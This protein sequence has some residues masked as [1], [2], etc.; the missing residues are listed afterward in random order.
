MPVS[1]VA[2]PSHP[3]VVASGR[4]PIAMVPRPQG[5]SNLPRSIAV[6][7]DRTVGKPGVERGPIELPLTGVPREAL[8]R[9]GEMLS[10]RALTD[11]ELATLITGGFGR[12]PL[13]D[14]M[15]PRLV[16]EAL[17]VA[18]P[19]ANAEERKIWEA[20]V[21][22]AV[23][24]PVQSWHERH[25]NP[26][27]ALVRP[28][29]SRM[30]NELYKR[31]HESSLEPASWSGVFPARQ[32]VSARIKELERVSRDATLDTSVPVRNGQGNPWSAAAVGAL[33]LLGGIP[34]AQA[35][36]VP[37]EADGA[38]AQMPLLRQQLANVASPVVRCLAPIGPFITR[39]PRATLA[40]LAGTLAA[41]LTTALYNQ[42]GHARTLV[43]HTQSEKFAPLAGIVARD[44]LANVTNQ[45]RQGDASL[46]AEDRTL[47]A[48]QALG[49]AADGARLLWQI[50]QHGRSDR[51]DLMS[52]G[53]DIEFGRW[54]IKQVFGD[55]VPTGGV[56]MTWS[57]W[58][59]P[60]GLRVILVPGKGDTVGVQLR[61]GDGS[62]IERQGQRGAVH[63]AEHLTF[64]RNLPDNVPFDDLYI[65]A[66]VTHNAYTTHDNTVYFTEG[67]Q[68]ALELILLEKSY[69]LAHATDPL[70]PAQLETERNVVFNELR[71]RD[72]S[73]QRASEV[74]ARAMYP[75]G[76]PYHA[77]P[78]GRMDDL[79]SLQPADVENLMRA[80]Q[81]PNLA[82]LVIS[83]N[84]DEEDVR[85]MV[86]HY[87]ADIEPG[88]T[89]PAAKP[90][91]QP[92]TDDTNDEMFDKVST[93]RLYRAWNVPQ[94]GHSDLPGLTLAARIISQ[95]LKAAL[96]N[97]MVFAGAFVDPRELGSQL[98][99]VLSLRGDADQQQ[100]EET[101]N[102]VMATF[103]EQ[104]PSGEEVESARRL[105]I[106]AE[107]HAQSSSDAI[108]TAVVH[109][110]DRGGDPDCA[111]ADIQAWHEAT[112]ASVKKV[113]GDWLARGSH[114]LLVTPGE[115][116]RLSPGN[117]GERRNIS[118][119]VGSPDPTLSATPTHVD[120]TVLPGMASPGPAFFPAVL[121]RELTNDLPVILAPMR[122]GADARV[123]FVFHGG[124]MGDL[125]PDT[126]VG[127]AKA[128]LRVLTQ[129]AGALEG[130]ALKQKLD[131][132]ELAVTARST[133]GYSR[134]TLEGPPSNLAQGAQIVKDMLTDTRFPA[135][136]LDQSHARARADMNLVATHPS[137]RGNVLM[138]TLVLG[139][140]H[141]YGRDPVGEGTDASLVAMSPAQ[142]ERWTA[143]YLDPSNATIV[144]VGP[145]DPDTLMGDLAASFGSV[146]GVGER[147]RLPVPVPMQ[148]AHP[149][150]HVF[151]TD[152]AQQSQVM[153]GYPSPR[154]GTADDALPTCIDKIIQRRV[155]T[156]LRE[157]MGV[158]Y[159]V[160]SMTTDTRGVR[161]CG[162]RSA[163]DAAYGLD[164]LATARAVV[165]DLLEGSK[166]VMQPELDLEI[167]SI[168]RD[169]AARY[170][171]RAEVE[172]AL[173]TAI[174]L[175]S[176]VPGDALAQRLQSL[177]C[178]DVNRAA[179]RMSAS[180]L[181]WLVSIPD[182][183]GD[184]PMDSSEPDDGNDAD[185]EL[186]LRLTGMGL[187]QF[188]EV[189]PDSGARTV[190]RL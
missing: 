40:T 18:L 26:P 20:V 101:L 37:G 23:R 184:T 128:A 65:A 125:D 123:V 177:T 190:H 56:D 91:I 15:A 52:P 45:V 39:H 16:T 187:S 103:L 121:R 64:R 72:D 164:A 161:M 32:G 14:A 54:L 60:N 19:E 83:G 115:R 44:V 122:E 97:E 99:I 46:P 113:V 162:F 120:R 87:F 136:L 35:E 143:R 182:A 95:R 71:Q 147:H 6:T 88:N 51:L 98:K 25:A 63:L 118:W 42:L 105:L 169:L 61:F 166:P 189:D 167:R 29:T 170:H 7:R 92:R 186:R 107:A 155:K 86:T 114:T 106:S 77:S 100:V 66:G 79:R 2:S 171:D 8:Q 152:Q 111:N 43:P 178:D 145:F 176:D 116:P 135:H 132:L 76:H 108:A 119:D 94:D 165:S 31:L 73:A 149:G 1:S 127:V 38:D 139:E 4:L 93:P 172:S 129:R 130:R 124:R 183:R 89:F 117:A 168:R 50:D 154:D 67:P 59:L 153:L 68:D 141:P 49:P 148:S 102:H 80:R 47:Q 157:Q 36:I 82:T 74:M 3:P 185:T 110:L 146:S 24:M 17:L 96:E 78:G 142:L 180:H 174:D 12:T 5:V 34:A 30:L 53:L 158:T 21:E 75:Y 81:R 160:R 173:V 112:P 55:P 133:E 179:G 90:D 109:C 151:R 10:G 144:A 156:T 126:G 85:R 138:E 58:S 84:V 57:D 9:L 48:V 28:A 41:G 140:D 181:T 70:S 27:P 22:D 104:G 137:L 188:T 163:V 134:I 131:D 150:V 159:G 62:K 11:R 13:G 69:R 33:V 175:N